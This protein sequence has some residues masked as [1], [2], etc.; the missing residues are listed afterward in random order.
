[1][2]NI[3][4]ISSLKTYRQANTARRRGWFRDGNKRHLALSGLFFGLGAAS[5][6]TC[7][8]AGAGLG[9]LWVLALR[10]LG[11]EGDTLLVNLSEN[12]RAEI[13]AQGGEAETLICYS[14]VNTLCKNTG[15]K[16]VRFFF[17]GAQ[18]ETVAGTL[19]WAGEFM[20]NIGLAEKGLEARLRADFKAAGLR[21]DSPYPL[22]SLAGPMAKAK[23]GR[24]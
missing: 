16:R 3:H 1:M 21:T 19:Y 13:Q 2:E 7:L 4:H 18:V 24:K 17:E 12:F 8:Y 20:Y 15:M 11:A 10:F 9:V 6:W 22:E 5:K 14:M 23:K